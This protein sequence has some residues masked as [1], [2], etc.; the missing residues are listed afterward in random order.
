MLAHERRPRALHGHGFLDTDYVALL[1]AGRRDLPA[2]EHD[3]RPARRGARRHRSAGPSSSPRGEA[4]RRR[5]TPRRGALAVGA[6]RRRPTSSSPRARPGAPRAC[7]APTPRRCAPSATGRDTVGLR[8]R[9]PLPD[10][11]P[12][13]PHASATRPGCLAVAHAGRDRRCPQ[14][15]FDADAVLERVGARADHRAAR[16][17]DALPV[18]PRPRPTRDRYDLSS[19]RLAVTGAAVIPVELIRRMRERA[20]LRDHHHR[21]RPHRG[22]RHRHRCA[23][24]TTTPRPSPHTSGRAIPGVEVRDRRRR[25][26]RGAARRARRGRGPRLQRDA[27]LL[28]RP[29][30]DR[31]GD[32]RRRLA[33]HRRHRGDGRRAATSASPTARRTCSSSAGSTPTRPRSRASLLGHPAIA[34]VAVVGVARR[35]PGRGGRGLRRA[36]GRARRSTPTRLIAWCRERMAN[37]KVPRRVEIVDELPVNATGK[38]LKY[39]LRERRAARR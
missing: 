18:D 23:A 17:A 16:A 13:L 34:Q 7:D 8:A 27:R 1:A 37:Y 30:G 25:R 32:R 36:D 19:L 14:P 39:E 33:A 38:V 28:R 2:L 26:P 29:R 21:L 35:A 22:E 24:P 11:H 20:R 6:G 9:R 12:V 31:G 4:R 5:P 15:V 3:R 10:G